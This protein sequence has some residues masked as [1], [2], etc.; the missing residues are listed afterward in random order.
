MS[1]ITL[2]KVNVS[3]RGKNHFNFCLIIRKRYVIPLSKRMRYLIL[4]QKESS[5]SS[6][7]NAK[8]LVPS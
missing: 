5:F 1:I 7:N 8:Y 3:S 4:S 6:S 2:S